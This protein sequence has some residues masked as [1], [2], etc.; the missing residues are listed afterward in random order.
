M[1][2]PTGPA[3][4]ARIISMRDSGPRRERMAEQLQPLPFAWDFFDAHTSPVSELVVHEDRWQRINGRMLNAAEV[5]CYSSHYTL[6]REHADSSTEGILM[7]LED[8]AILD[9]TY[10]AEPALLQDLVQAYGYVRFHCHLIAPAR[11][12][13][14]QDRRRV[15]R[16]RRPVHGTLAYCLDRRTA[17]RLVDRLQ[18]VYRPVDVEMDRYW[19][20]GVPINCLYPFV[21][22]ERAAPTQIGSR[23]FRRGNLVDHLHWK[24]RNQMEKA[25]RWT[26]ELA[27]LL[28]GFSP[29]WERRA[30]D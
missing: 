25:G 27:Y 22:I 8:D 2:Q 9:T 3:V 28:P 30:D 12:L 1:V 7:V 19:V 13:H 15:L 18:H 5:G 21:A 29:E 14:Y 26:A 17:R 10:L 6:W 23:S 11:T 20:H 24:T 16:F 4:T